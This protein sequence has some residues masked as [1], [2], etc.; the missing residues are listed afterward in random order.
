M[1]SNRSSL[2]TRNEIIVLCGSKEDTNPFKYEVYGAPP[3]FI[4]FGFDLMGEAETH[5]YLYEQSV[6]NPNAPR[7]PTVYDSFEIGHIGFRRGFI[8]M[9]DTEAPTVEYWLKKKPDMAEL[10]YDKVA[11][12][13][14]WVLNCPLPPEPR[15]GPVG[16]GPARHAAF[17]DCTAP[18]EFDSTDAL[19]RYF[20]VALS[21]FPKQWA[22]TETVDFSNEEIC[23][24]HGNIEPSNFHYDPETQKVTII[25][26]QDV[27][28]GPKSFASYQFHMDYHTD[29]EFHRAIATRIDYP[30]TKSID[31]MDRAFSYLVMCSDETLGLDKSGHRR[32]KPSSDSKRIAAASRPR[33]R[34]VYIG[35]I[36]ENYY[37]ILHQFEATVNR[38]W[39]I[40]M[41]RVRGA[42][43]LREIV[44]AR[45]SARVY[46]LVAPPSGR[47]LRMMGSPDNHSSLPTRKAIVDACAP[48]KDT[49]VLKYEVDGG[50]P[51]FI[52]FGSNLEGGAE[53]QKYL[54]EQSLLNANAPRVPA[55]YDTFEADNG[56]YREAYIVMEYIEAPTV[57]EWLNKEPDMA[58]LL[59]DE[60]AEAVRWILNC[61][62]PAEPRFGPVGRGPA[63]HRVFA[64]HVAP[65]EFDSVDAVQ[66]YFNAALNRF[67]PRG[68]TPIPPVDF[69]NEEVCF[70]HCD[71]RPA[72]FH[73][74][75]ETQEVT[76]VDLQSIGMGPK[77]FASYPF[78]VEHHVD[79]Q[80]HRAIAT[81]IDYPP[82][83]NIDGMG[84]ASIY[85]I[86]CGNRTLGLDKS[87][88]RRP[89]P[90]DKSKMRVA[91]K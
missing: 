89:K 55:V 14:R 86:M 33:D 21:R 74:D 61:P 53:T 52:K 12:A 25:N 2:P 16:C 54:Y 82:T 67:T 60:V 76:I 27:G 31:G 13:V 38:I 6:R 10:L 50:Q 63:Q 58:E 68:A 17:P 69:S 36:A 42:L 19:Q 20:N 43:R 51:L 77:S 46:Q 87:G 35:Q 91:A 71:I 39:F 59:C 8:V 79:Y 15:F 90:L 44:S 7:L 83:E 30:R 62:L 85:L 75:P 28:M 81:R 70:Y 84:R 47:R 73:F 41:L 64:D 9:E 49:N 72:N 56:Y 26:P 80:F 48:P 40:K 18:L 66:R 34:I 78:H 65:L 3:L 32:P 22:I 1:T 88:H 29:R 24:Y 37:S 23:F 11:E 4:K 45:D 5:K 57:E